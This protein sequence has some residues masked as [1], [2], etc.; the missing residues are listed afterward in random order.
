[1]FTG[2]TVPTDSKKSKLGS[3]NE[4]AYLSPVKTNPVVLVP[5]FIWKCVLTATSSGVDISEVN[6]CHLLQ[7]MSSQ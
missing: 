7:Q 1:M 2:C 4:E 3:T 6:G 5:C